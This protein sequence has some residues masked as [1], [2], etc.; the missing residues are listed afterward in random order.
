VTKHG[1]AATASDTAGRE[2]TREALDNAAAAS[3]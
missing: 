2:W 3:D 1:Q